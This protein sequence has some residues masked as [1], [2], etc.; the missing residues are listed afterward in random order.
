MDKRKIEVGIALLIIVA[1]IISFVFI[2]IKDKK[3]FVYTGKSGNYNFDVEQIGSVT[4]YRPHVF[5][6]G[7]E[8]IYAFR[9][10]PND[11]KN[12]D[13]EDNLIDKLNRPEGLKDLYITKEVNL[14]EN[15]EGSVNIVTAPMVSILGRSD[16]GIYKVRI[17]SA[18]TSFHAGEPVA[19]IVDCST[20]NYNKNI[21]MSVGVVYLKLGNENKIYSDG[22][23]IVIEGKDKDGL[24]KSGEKFA[25][26]L[27][28][29]F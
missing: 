7:K 10:K 29:V 18:Y 6:N 2:I 8:Y 20:V 28:G 9:N 17:T 24:I 3:N 4:F 19:P 27:I 1:V 12:I 26:S 5:V 23:C 21:N 14:S 11:V 25:Y 13:L 22:D 15:I 16:F